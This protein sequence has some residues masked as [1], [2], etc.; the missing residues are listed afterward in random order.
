MNLLGVAELI[1]YRTGV[2]LRWTMPHDI[3]P[4][5]RTASPRAARNGR[6]PAVAL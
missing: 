1:T 5:L 6:R 3:P 4:W 2:P